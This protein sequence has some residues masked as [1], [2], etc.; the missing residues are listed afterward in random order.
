MRQKL[1]NESRCEFHRVVSNAASLQHPRF[2]Y[3][4]YASDP[5]GRHA[6]RCFL[7]IASCQ[8]PLTTGTQPTIERNH[9]CVYMNSSFPT[10]HNGLTHTESLQTCEMFRAR[11]GI[12]NYISRMIHVDRWFSGFTFPQH[13]AVVEATHPK[14]APFGYLDAQANWQH[15]LPNSKI[16]QMM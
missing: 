16:L 1:T 3:R 4:Q 8:S 2:A 9:F 6:E 13:R 11:T 12:W 10:I 5:M 14:N 15:V 7:H